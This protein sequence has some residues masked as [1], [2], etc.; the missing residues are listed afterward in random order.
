MEN[1]VDIKLRP[2]KQIEV[3]KLKINPLNKK[4]FKSDLG[5]ETDQLYN[6]IK[7]R[8]IL[9][10]L[11]AKTD[12]T[13]LAGH[14]R[15][16][17]AKELDFETVPV[18]FIENELT[19]D[20]EKKFIVKDNVLRRH[21]SAEERKSFYRFLIPNFDEKVM[22]KNSSRMGVNY[23]EISETTGINPKTVQ[24]DITHIRQKNEKER[25]KSIE[26]DPP[27]E[28][29]IEIFKRAMARMLNVAILGSKTTLTEFKKIMDSGIERINSITK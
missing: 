29:E 24:Y 11:I 15:F 19:E 21:L 16:M 17:I 4:F 9:V 23:K 3:S 8:G 18:Q 26:V 10:P 7:D 14:R 27:N 28:K 1:K 2:I 5:G 13:L 12:G 22:I 6:D 25:I 20:E